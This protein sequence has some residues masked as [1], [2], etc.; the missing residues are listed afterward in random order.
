MAGLLVPESLQETNSPCLSGE[1]T[2]A[3]AKKKD[4]GENKRER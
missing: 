3:E 1:E 4:R 2:W